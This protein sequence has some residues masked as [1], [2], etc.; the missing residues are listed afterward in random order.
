VGAWGAIA[1]IAAACGPVVGGALST[2]VS[3]RLVFF[4]NVPIGLVAFVTAGRRVPAP[5]PD[6]RRGLDLAGQAAAVVAL[7]G[8]TLVLIEGGRLGWRS[9]PVVGG[10]AVALSAVA[11]FLAMER[12]AVS[13]VLPR[14]LFAGRTFPAATLVGLLINLGFY[15]QLFVFNLL[16]QQGRGL[17]PLRAGLGVLPQGILVSL[18]SWA[19]G[20]FT[21]RAGSPRPTMLAGLSLGAVGLAGLAAAG[22][23]AAYPVLVAPLAAS[24]L[25]MSVTMPAA[26]SAV[27]ESAPSGRA[28]IASGVINAA[29]QVGGV[30]G[31][32][33]L[34]TLVSGGDLTAGYTTALA[35]AA[36]AFALGAAV[37]ALWVRPDRV[38]SAPA[39][40]SLG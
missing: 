19:S 8:L 36:G 39:E 5:A 25:G 38:A 40:A 7:A 10:G 31:V 12:R 16:L 3:W 20:R 15:G 17:S 23:R 27:V 24:G 22:P 33:L 14:S 21:G 2:A 9:G 34:G 11:A 6:P 1:G 29:R 4:L 37:T 13:P 28:G 30:I 35:V 18:G 32:A 26:T